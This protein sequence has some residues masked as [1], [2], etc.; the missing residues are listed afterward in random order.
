[1][2][3][4]ECDPAEARR[5]LE[6]AGVDTDNGNTEHELWRA[7]Y[8]G[9]TAVAYHDKVVVQGSSPA[10]L[11]GLL[12]DESGRAYL[13]FD[14]GSRGNPGPSAI[15]WVIVTDDGVVAEDG[16]RIGDATNNQAEYQ[17]LLAGLRAA[18]GAGFDDLH[19]RGDAELVV[20]Q[21]RGEYDVN[22]P[23]LRSYRVEAL[24]LLQDVE[25]W[26]IQHVPRSVN[27]RADT[28]VNEALDG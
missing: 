18:I 3:V 21:I 28:L 11:T 25:S 17:A 23:T 14:G 1:M 16:K 13:Y 20:K 19:I 12:R 8:E 15:G 7:T 27:E 10:A 2:P 4:I 6:A 24:E 5:R 9:G 22:N 26:E